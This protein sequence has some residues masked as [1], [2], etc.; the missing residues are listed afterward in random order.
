M[1]FK[2]ALKSFEETTKNKSTAATE[3]I[4]KSDFKSIVCFK[5]RKPGHKQFECK[6]GFRPA[7]GFSSG[8]YSNE[9]SKWCHICRKSNHYTR[10]CR[11]NR[12]NN[13]SAKHVAVDDTPTHGFA[14]KI[15]DSDILCADN[16]CQNKLLVDCG[17]TSHIVCDADKF[18][19]FNDNFDPTSHY[20]ELADGS[21]SNNLVYGRGDAN[22]VLVDCKGESHD[23]LLKNALCIPSYKQDIFSVRSAVDQGVAV[24]FSPKGSELVAANG[25]QF[26]LNK[27]NNLYYLNNLNDNLCKSRSLREWHKVLGHCNTKDVLK[28]ETVVEGMKITNKDNFSCES[29][30]KGKMCEYR[31]RLPDLKA[32][33][34]LDLVH[35]DLA[36]PIEPEARDGFRYSAVFVDDYSGAVF[37]HLLK[38]KSNTIDAAKKFLSDVAPYGKVK[39]I[40]SDNGTEFTSNCFRE[41]LLSNKI[42]HEFSAPHS[43]H[44]NG[45]AE[46][47]WRSIFEMTRCLL[48]DSGLPKYLWSYAVK[49]AAYIRNRCY[50][51][52]TKMTAYES[53][54]TKKPNIGNMHVFGEK[55]FAYVQQKKKLDPRSEEGI[56]V[57]Y[58]QCSPAYLIYFPDRNVVKRIR[59]VKFVNVVNE[60]C[61]FPEVDEQLE[62]VKNE[63]PVEG[64]E[65]HETRRYPLRVRS[66]PKY[67][68]DYVTSV[69][70]EMSRIA[71]CSVDYCYKVEDIPNDYY[72]AMN[73]DQSEEWK[74]AMDDEMQAL[75]D[76]NTFTVAT[77]PEGKSTIG[78]C[79]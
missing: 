73:S 18:V 55:C 60:D 74:S 1:D 12:G 66:R 15:S 34:P 25:T 26:K 62:S 79:C 50:N 68:S 65:T 69:D 40:R 61:S 21:R 45:T 24:S 3:K 46:R 78:I 10:D 57:G 13:N 23:V 30:I 14:M 2:S 58:D 33:H 20:I 64:D 53:L 56:F 54:T 35:C 6:S 67:L 49:A 27:I 38:N 43:P 63:S 28:L 72:E 4:M 47:A 51:N 76:S 29:C 37:V 75:I 39:C 41:L 17:A 52:R 77:L 7:T 8:N 22:V 70:E 19:S 32:K 44:Q 11:R 59:C 16:V 31:N 5:C 42:K 71:K 9:R 36:G 48:I